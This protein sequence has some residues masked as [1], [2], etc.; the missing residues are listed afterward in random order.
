[1]VLPDP[2]LI[3]ST[4]GDGPPAVKR[5]K[6][7]K[8]GKELLRAKHRPKDSPEFFKA[9]DVTFE[10]LKNDWHRVSWW[11]QD[12]SIDVEREYKGLPSPVFILSRYYR[13]YLWLVTGRE[14]RNI[15][16]LLIETFKT[17]AILTLALEMT[18]LYNY[19]CERPAGIL[20]VG[21]PQINTIDF[22]LND[23]RCDVPYV[24]TFAR[25]LMLQHVTNTPQKIP[26]G[27]NLTGV[28]QTALAA[29]SKLADYYDHLCDS[30]QYVPTEIDAYYVNLLVYEVISLIILLASIPN[31][32]FAGTFLPIDKEEI[33]K[34]ENGIGNTRIKLRDDANSLEKTYWF[35][36]VGLSYGIIIFLG[37]SLFASGVVFITPTNDDVE[38]AYRKMTSG[39]IL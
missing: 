27:V 17:I 33:R 15:L 21:F 13:L 5:E 16:R 38:K 35:T 37:S 1:M 39:I 24:L 22:A 28:N 19:V 11:K 23:M 25:P 6:I 29:Y 32:K 26:G 8:E 31:L 14:F 20:A 18:N 10:I 12:G 2:S 4:C 3:E 30:S 36:R 34:T 7:V 9:G